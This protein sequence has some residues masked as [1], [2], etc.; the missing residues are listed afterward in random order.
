[1]HQQ[2]GRGGDGVR[3]RLCIA[4]RHPEP[5]QGYVSDCSLTRAASV[6]AFSCGL[7]ACIAETVAVLNTIFMLSR[8][9]VSR[10]LWLR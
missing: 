10:K 2:L 8:L 9:L 7:E 3:A 4:A 6:A 5:M 1:M